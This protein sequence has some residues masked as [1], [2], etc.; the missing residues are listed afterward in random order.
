MN[1]LIEC[2]PNFSEGRRQDVIDAIVEEMARS[3]GV[4]ILDVSSDPDHNRTVVTMVGL[5]QEIEKAAF[6]GIQ[7]ASELIDMNV[8]EGVHPRFGATDVMPFVPLREASMDDCM[9]IAHQ[10]GR[11]VTM[12]LEIPVYFYG[13]A[14][15]RPEYEDMVAIRRPSFQYEQLKERI[16]VDPFW[17]PDMG[18][19]E[20]G[21]AGAILIGA[22]SVMIAF[23]V[24]LNTPDMDI[25]HQIAAA[26]RA[27]GGG[28]QFVRSTAVKI[29]E[30]AQINLNLLDYMQTPLHRALELIRLEAGRFGVN[31]TSTELIGLMP[32]AALQTSA[33]WYLQM[34]N[35]RDDLS[36]EARIAQA[37][38]QP[39]ALGEEEPPVPDDAT[40]QIVLPVRDDARRPEQ[41]P[42]AIAQPTAAPGG[43]A[44]S[45]LTGALA[46]S[47]T[48]MVA[49]LTVGKKGYG[50]VEE[51]MIAIQNAAYQL[52]EQ[53]L[54]AVAED[55]DAINHLMTT[56]RRARN[57]SDAAREVQTATLTA[58]E[59][60]LRVARALL[61]VLQLL[62]Q[63]VE[64]GNHN[65]VIDGAVGVHLAAAAF[66][67]A[68]LN[69]RVNLLGLT[70]E[71]VVRRYTDEINQ[72]Q[73]TARPLCD[74]I[75]KTANERAG[76]TS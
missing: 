75:L 17:V 21:S 5:P 10:L 3:G 27:S 16:G 8:H 39:T 44:A 56:I 25:A 31:V 43:G 59:V 29:G 53:L 41:L 2:V 54:D 4:H 68:C 47:L 38:S 73:A 74:S 34:G 35:W 69:M 62:E 26:V 13:A 49:A 15:L 32:E 71:D 1:P 20:L 48:E 51:N 42:I 28:L 64:L 33:A 24:F 14:A 6:A 65:A 66:E 18:P 67:S 61:D 70:D 46:A 58:A 45:S 63:V 12:E 36:L 40:S 60:P 52:R 19:A 9:V 57:E 30:R 11:R 55:I 76:L 22:R 72:L 37:E 50:E 7:A 23:N